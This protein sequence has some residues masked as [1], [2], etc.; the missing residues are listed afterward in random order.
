MKILTDLLTG[1]VFTV[2]TLGSLLI[3]FLLITGI[4]IVVTKNTNLISKKTI[5]KN[6]SKFATIYG[7]IYIIFSI[8]MVTTLALGMILVNYI[9]LF[10]LLTGAVALIM[11]GIQFFLSKKYKIRN[12][13]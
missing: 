1:D 4:M 10:I 2:Y 5:Y 3:L 9:L 11:V 12:I 7:W 8:L 13:K 6:P